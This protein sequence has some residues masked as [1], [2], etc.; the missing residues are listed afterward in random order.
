MSEDLRRL[1]RLIVDP[2]WAPIAVATAFLLMFGSSF[3]EQHDYV[4]HLAG[5]AAIAYFV[6]RTITIV[7]A[8]ARRIAPPKR[9]AVTFLATL[10][11]AVL[12][13]VAELAAGTMGVVLQRGLGETVRDIAY[14][15]LGAIVFVVLAR[16]VSR[17]VPGSQE[18][19]E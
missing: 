13:E 1:L 8:L 12:W 15:A 3:T 10:V 2:G 18:P 5:G 19:T 17:R 14:G 7:P 9:P 16:A 4:F 6:W 11:V